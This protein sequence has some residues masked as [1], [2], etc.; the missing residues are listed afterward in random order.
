MKVAEVRRPDGSLL[1]K[2]EV[3]D[4]FLTRGLGLLGRR[5]LASDGGLLIEPCSSVHTLF[6]RF[7]I[8]VLYLD[9]ENV[10]VKAASMPAFRL[11]L[12]GKEAKK[13][14][15]LPGGAIESRGV[16]VGERLTLSTSPPA[17]SP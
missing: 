16:S 9:R 4:N 5:S 7:P 12:G 3:A 1:C 2:A 11:S 8:D 6:M 10:V 14:L 15:E 13:V 17:P